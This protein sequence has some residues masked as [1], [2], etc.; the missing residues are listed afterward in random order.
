MAS[1]HLWI[2]APHGKNKIEIVVAFGKLLGQHDVGGTLDG[3]ACVQGS[4]A[5]MAVQPNGV[6]VM[7][8]KTF[9][10]FFKYRL[11]DGKDARLALSKDTLT[12]GVGSDTG[13]C[14]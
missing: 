9:N 8:A 5:A 14:V 1:K 7:N 4:I 11:P 12:L 3:G 13:M 10:V 2:V 6:I